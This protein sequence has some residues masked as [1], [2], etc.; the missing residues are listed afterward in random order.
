MVPAGRTAAWATRVL[1][2]SLAASP[3]STSLPGARLAATDL[4]TVGQQR[5]LDVLCSGSTVALGPVKVSVMDHGTT[6][7]G[8]TGP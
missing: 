3:P 4:V 6:A 7:G 2:P 8:T 5:T 1:Q